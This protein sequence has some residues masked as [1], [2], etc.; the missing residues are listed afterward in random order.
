[1]KVY[2]AYK[3]TSWKTLDEHLKNPVNF[4]TGIKSGILVVFFSSIRL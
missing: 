3:Y 2:P 4:P 1:M